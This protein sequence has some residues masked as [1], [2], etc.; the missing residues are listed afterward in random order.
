MLAINYYFNLLE[1]IGQDDDA[2]SMINKR[3]VSVG[4]LMQN[5]L[6]VGLS[7]L[8]KTTRERMSAK[9]PEKITPK[10]ITNN[11]LVS[12]QMKTFFNSSKLS[13][14]MDQI[15]ALAEISN[16]RRITSL[17][18]G[19]LNRDT[20]QFEVRDVHATHYGRIC[21]IE[22]PEGPNIGLILNLATYASVN[23]YGFL[24]TPYFKVE[25]SVV[26]YDNV[27]YLTVCWRIWIQ[28]CSI[29]SNCWW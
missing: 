26:D 10:N 27:V 12:N 28:H 7:K 29:N 24:Q 3:I 16:E 19:G 18:P 22:T 4:E 23:E 1:G 25:N 17:G 8:E 9:E 14:F 2:D 13:Q 5:Q 11:K 21:P 15:N 6:N 20:A